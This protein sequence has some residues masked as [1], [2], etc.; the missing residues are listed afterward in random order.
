MSILTKLNSTDKTRLN[1][2]ARAILS[3]ILLRYRKNKN[4]LLKDTPLSMVSV[5]NQPYY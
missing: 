3:S 2:L 5:K 1:K 4:N